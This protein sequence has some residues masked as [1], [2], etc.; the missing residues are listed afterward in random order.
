MWAKEQQCSTL[1]S[2]QNTK[3]E[4]LML[5]HFSKVVTTGLC[6]CFFLCEGRSDDCHQRHD[7]RK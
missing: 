4:N 7:D 5:N 1:D 3:V 6:G 2:R